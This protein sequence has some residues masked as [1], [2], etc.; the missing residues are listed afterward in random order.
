MENVTLASHRLRKITVEMAIAA[1]L[2]SR[3]IAA[4]N[5]DE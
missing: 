1:V 2:D 4:K 3:F 5:E